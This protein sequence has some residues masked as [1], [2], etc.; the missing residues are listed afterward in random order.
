MVYSIKLWIPG[1][2]KLYVLLDFNEVFYFFILKKI[3]SVFIITEHTA[4]AINWAFWTYHVCAV[5]QLTAAINPTGALAPAANNASL[6]AAGTMTMTRK[7]STSVLAKQSCYNNWFFFP[8]SA[9]LHLD[10]TICE[11]SSTSLYEKS[12]IDS[13]IAGML[14]V[15]PDQ[16]IQ[17]SEPI[18]TNLQ[19]FMAQLHWLFNEATDEFW[20]G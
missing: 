11:F 17:P 8:S 12:S 1:S 4:E 9:M 18:V 5:N 6:H 15:L 3:T 2:N 14:T 19:S 7:L 16:S 10:K 20:H 13:C